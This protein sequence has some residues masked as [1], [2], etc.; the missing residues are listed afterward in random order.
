MQ[1][2]GALNKDAASVKSFCLGTMHM[3]ADILSIAGT[4]PPGSAQGAK[5]P[6]SASGFHYIIV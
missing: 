1:S 2:K 6:P 4:Y 5:A 3:R